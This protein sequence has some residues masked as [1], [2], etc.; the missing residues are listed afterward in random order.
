MINFKFSFTSYAACKDF[1]LIKKSKEDSYQSIESFIANNSDISKKELEL[2]YVLYRN[3]EKQYKDFV[4][5]CSQY[6]NSLPLIEYK[7]PDFFQNPNVI[8]NKS[9]NMATYFIERMADCM[10]TARFFTLKSYEIIDT[11]DNIRWDN[12]YQVQYYY[13]CIYFGTAVTWYSNAFDHI[14]QIAFWGLKLYTSAKDKKKKR[15][16]DSWSDNKILSFCDYDFVR[17]QLTA[18]KLDDIKQ[19]ITTCYKE[20][21]KVRKWANYIKHKGGLEY[22]FLYPD[23]P[24]DIYITPCESEGKK[25]KVSPFKSPVQIDIDKEFGE[26]KKVYNALYGC[27]NKIISILEDFKFENPPSQ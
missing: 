17:S 15:Y 1:Y 12:G 8:L 23:D 5:D 6:I 25:V 18:R 19:Q 4:N 13:R 10:Q 27:T 24:Y 2:C 16:N 11:N 3:T 26:L 22:L 9:F 7:K 21:E 20:F 14:L